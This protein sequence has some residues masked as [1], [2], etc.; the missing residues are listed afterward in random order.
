MRVFLTKPFVRFAKKKH[1]DEPFLAEGI[2]RFEQGLN[3]ADLGGGIYKIR[4]ARIGQGTS[5]GYRTIIACNLNNKLFFLYAFAKN[6]SENISKGD[7]QIL[8]DAGE[9]LMNYNDEELN[10]LLKIGEIVELPYA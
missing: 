10:T 8:R 9:I 7:L 6:E 2:R 3:V 5:H 4:I 1:I